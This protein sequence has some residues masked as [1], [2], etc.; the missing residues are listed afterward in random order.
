MHLESIRLPLATWTLA[1]AAAVSCGAPD[2]PRGPT[3][4]AIEGD[5]ASATERR[6]PDAPTD[7]QPPGGPAAAPGVPLTDEALASRC[8]GPE[9]LED[10]A[11]DAFGETFQ[12]SIP[13]LEAHRGEVEARW[14]RALEGSH[15]YAYGLAWL[16]SQDALPLLRARL[17]ADRYFYGWETD[18]PEDLDVRLRDEQYP[19]HLA[20]ILAI[21]RISGREL[22]DAVD[23]RP[24]EADR[25]IAETLRQPADSDAD[26]ARW[27]LLKLL[28]P[29]RPVEAAVAIAPTAFADGCWEARA[30]TIAA[31]L[32]ACRAARA[33]G[34]AWQRRLCRCDPDEIIEVGVSDPVAYYY[35]PEG[36]GGAGPT[37]LAAWRACTVNQLE[38][39]AR[40][41][42]EECSC[43]ERGAT[44]VLGPYVRS[45]RVRGRESYDDP[46]VNVFLD[47]VRGWWLDAH[48]DPPCFVAGTAVATPEGPRPIESLRPGDRVLAQAPGAS[49]G[50]I[51][52]VLRVKTRRTSALVRLTLA[53]GRTITTTP[54]HPFYVPHTDAWIDAGDLRSGD[55]VLTRDPEGALTTIAIEATA[56]REE[57]AE[58]HGIS[59]S[60]PN[61]Y[62]AGDV[63]VH[64]Y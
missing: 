57:D 51:A 12:D 23:L 9:G 58:V 19:H 38:Y 64:N 10:C 39:R 43:P 42:E 33:H 41:Y 18:H 21:E 55:E 6:R 48:G 4:G 11:P 40:G 22:A 60:P 59:V 30:S 15:A 50:V 29:E 49:E 25:L 5:S 47:P 17:L 37:P 2:S 56:R 52:T 1:L 46:E 36:C 14:L 63:L 20:Y 44:P 45:K 35:Y 32:A 34:D 62:F 8:A 26:V 16:R 54:N 28:R 31:A 7:L 3:L 13:W 53:G 27:L 61:T 24:E